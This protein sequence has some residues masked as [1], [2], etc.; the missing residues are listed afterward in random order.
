MEEKTLF[1]DPGKA[2]R[3][4]FIAGFLMLNWGIMGWFTIRAPSLGFAALTL[5]LGLLAFIGALS[6]VR[7]A[8]SA[9]ELPLIK[10]TD[11]SFT[12]RPYTRSQFVEIPWQRMR[13]NPT[14][15]PSKRSKAASRPRRGHHYA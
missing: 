10:W 12:F 8:R 13:L 6:Q 5:V 11:D 15:T 2:L 1:A 9:S 7:A 3:G 14:S 4:R